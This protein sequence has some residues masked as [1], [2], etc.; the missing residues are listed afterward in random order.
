[1]AGLVK[2]DYIKL[3]PNKFSPGTGAVVIQD[4]EVFPRDEFAAI[5]SGL[6]GAES[7]Q[8]AHLLHVAH[9]RRDLK[10]LQLGVDGMQPA[11]QVLEKQVESL[12]KTDELGALH[13]ERCNLCSS[14]LYHFALVV[15]WSIFNGR[16]SRVHR[17]AGLGTAG[18]GS[19]LRSK[20]VSGRSDRRRWRRQ[21]GRR[22]R[23]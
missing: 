23:S 7:A 14:H 1:M 12:R 8:D 10:P 18:D 16:W 19:K 3:L 15:L 13:R 6:N 9:H 4:L 2:L 17:F 21:G 5:D 11:D 20:L 22:R